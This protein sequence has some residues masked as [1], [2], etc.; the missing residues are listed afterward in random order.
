MPTPV[1]Q[2]TLIA[3]CALSQVSRPFAASASSK[4]AKTPPMI[5]NDSPRQAR[6]RG[7]TLILRIE[8]LRDTNVLR[9]GKEPKRFLAAFAAD[10]ARFH[11]A[12]GHPQIP[13]K[14]AIYPDGAGVNLF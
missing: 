6:N 7:C 1:T 8:L 9:F 11:S 14:P 5:A 13:N 4:M 10:P 3:N 2:M 12:K